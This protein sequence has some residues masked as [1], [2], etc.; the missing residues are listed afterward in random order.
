MTF[1]GPPVPMNALPHGKNDACGFVPTA[2][3][4]VNSK[5]V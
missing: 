5:R 3:T 1:G 4:E 2:Y